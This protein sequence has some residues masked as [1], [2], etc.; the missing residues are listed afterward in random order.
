MD[1]RAILEN[2]IS[3]ER[4]P[5]VKEEEPRSDSGGRSHTGVSPRKG[6]EVNNI[7]KSGAN[8]AR[9]KFNGGEYDDQKEDEEQRWKE[10]MELADQL[11]RSIEAADG[12]YILD[13][14]RIRQRRSEKEK[15]VRA[16]KRVVPVYTP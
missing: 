6:I 11:D 4:V 15:D 7:T 10:R 14:I 1:E 9:A 3:H 16:S 5:V 8:T 13:Q 2:K 12:P